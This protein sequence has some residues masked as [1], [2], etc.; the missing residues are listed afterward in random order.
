MNPN[1]LIKHFVLIAII[2]MIS[3]CSLP[4]RYLVGAGRAVRIPQVVT[5][6]EPFLRDNQIVISGKIILDNPTESD[7]LLDKIFLRVKGDGGRVISKAELDWARPQIKSRGQIESPVEFFLPLHILNQ[8]SIQISLKTAVIYKVLSI[9]IPI[10]SEIAVFHL[11]P[12][13][14]SLTGPL[15]VTMRTKINSD[16]LGSALVKYQFD[17]INPFSVDLS[18]EEGEFRVST[19]E[20]GEIGKTQMQTTLLGSKKQTQIKGEFL[21]HN[22]F[23]DVFVDEFIK[24][25]AIKAVLSG[26]LRLPQTDIFI[27]FR[28]EAVQEIDFSLFSNQKK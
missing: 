15:Q 19:E 25:H 8:Q 18:F 11:A 10:E 17:I 9:R 1:R 3:G 27:P 2:G 13:R 12:L 24:G 6:L 7:L 23:R 21:V 16:L 4:L 26:K 22:I 14:N 20:K 28:V 5:H